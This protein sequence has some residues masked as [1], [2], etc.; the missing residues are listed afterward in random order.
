MKGISFLSIGSNVGQREHYIQQAILEIELQPELTLLKKG[1]VIETDPLEVMDQPMFLNTV[2]KIKS[3]LSPLSLLDVLQ[4]IERKAGRIFRYEKGPREIDIDILSY[5]ELEEDY[6][7][8]LSLPHHSLFSRPFIREIL[9]N[10]GEDYIYN[11]F[12]E[13]R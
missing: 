8:R 5:D 12:K 6:S 2:I 13:P 7:N 9:K 10:M 11:Y 1:P 4:D 3:C